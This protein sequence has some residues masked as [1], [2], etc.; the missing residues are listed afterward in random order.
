[1]RT[2]TYRT[3]L[4]IV[5]EGYDRQTEWFQPRVGLIPPST[6]VLTMTRAQLWGS[7]IFSAL[8]E[9]RSDDL[10]RTWS[11]PVAHP[12]LDRRRYP[13]GVEVCPCD[14]TPDWHAAS[15]T[16]LLV[17]HT[18]NYFPGERGELVTNESHTI[19]VSYA[20]Y[21]AEA[22]A[23]SAWATM[24]LPDRDRFF[25]ISAGCAQRVELPNGDLLLPL[26]CMD[27]E[28]TARTHQAGD[29]FVTVVRCAFDGTT[30]RYLEHGSELTVAGGRGLCEPSLTR[31]QGKYYLTIRNDDR[32]YLAASDDGL[33]F[34]APTPWV[35]DDGA[36]LG[37]YNTQQHWITHSDGLFLSYTRR[38]AQNDHVFRHRA[39]LFLAEVDPARRCVLHDT[40][41]EI[42]PDTGAQL[43]NFGALNVT[44]DESWVVTSECMQGDAEDPYD[45]AR[46]EARGANNR[47][48][49]CRI[50]WNTPN[51][52]LDNR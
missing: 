34:D 8:Q 44:P 39:P 18:A 11:A 48:Y 12:T 41:R 22:R 46:T 36:D 24:D 21:D 10:G 31:Y 51:R 3:Q 15:G 30:L 33:H 23:W 52:L 38:G 50:L 26:Y 20:V 47:V 7:D 6:A 17:G 9:M 25:L 28:T 13:D 45:I 27:R 14:M 1:M 49:I 40:E 4:G 16:L 5:T 32:G 2:I 29:W 42:V 35:F 43:G 37:S 19:D